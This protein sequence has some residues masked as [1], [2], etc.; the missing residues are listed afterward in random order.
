MSRIAN[1]LTIFA[2]LALLLI[3]C[4]S[5]QKSQALLD[6]EQ[7]FAEAK[8]NE[9]ILRYAPA[10]LERAEQ[11]LARA[12]VADNEED[13]SS[14]TYV[15]T[16]RIETARAIAARKTA[17]NRLQ[18][19]GEVKNKE[20]LKAREIEIQLEQQAK[21]EALRDKEAALMEREQALAKAEALRRELEELQALKTERGMVMTLGDVL[22]SS[23]KTD[24][25]P[26]AMSTIDKLASFLG[27]YPEK[28]VL[29]EGH[30]DNVGTEEYN[31]D[32]SERR[33]L[34]VKEALVQ[35]GVDASR[36]DTLGLGESTPITDN[37][38]AAGR[39]KN[40]RVEIVIRD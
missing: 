14:L 2:A 6:A 29:I 30:T 31:L 3:A 17:N 25:L 34:S 28:T 5:T 18:E 36:I 20:R 19:L 37:T 12:A 8:Q 1:R 22:F 26:G 33:A 16:S 15:G 40:R 24:L 35:V 11:A 32:L 4:S 21:A 38:T 39:L 27:E 13:M 9:E 23:G 10:E 7:T